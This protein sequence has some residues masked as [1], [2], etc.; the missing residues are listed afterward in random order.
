MCK[1]SDLY[2]RE[3]GLILMITMIRVPWLIHRATTMASV[4]CFLLT[5]DKQNWSPG[6]EYSPRCQTII[7]RYYCFGNHY[8]TL[9]CDTAIGVA[10]LLKWLSIWSFFKLLI[11]STHMPFHMVKYDKLC[12]KTT[13][14]FILALIVY[15]QRS[16]FLELIQLLYYEGV[17]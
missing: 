11:K 4:W 10:V 8:V 7:C 16:Y 17:S 15:M 2:C 1:T 6:N 14:S 5:M 13:Q 12:I 3:I 9:F